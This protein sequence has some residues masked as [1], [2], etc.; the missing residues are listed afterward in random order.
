M[1]RKDKSGNSEKSE[2]VR[3]V[4]PYCYENNEYSSS[5]D[6]TSLKCKRCGKPLAGNAGRSRKELKCL[7]CHMGMETSEGIWCL[8][9][10]GHVDEEMVEKCEEFA[11]R[12]IVHSEEDDKDERQ[13]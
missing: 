2:I 3:L 6:D 9:F 8:K 11:N 13:D 10:K 4:C 5:D 7:D 12:K 1:T